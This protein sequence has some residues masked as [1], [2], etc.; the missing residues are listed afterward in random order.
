MSEED[1]FAIEKEKQENNTEMK[2]MQVDVTE[3]KEEL[4]QAINGLKA[5]RDLTIFFD[6]HDSNVLAKV[7]LFGLYTYPG[8]SGAPQYKKFALERLG[9]RI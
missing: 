6:T 7:R 5:V 4:N 9:I 3:I 8:I 2:P 1:L